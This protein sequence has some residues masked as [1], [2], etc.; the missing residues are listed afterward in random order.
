MKKE[1]SFQVRGLNLTIFLIQLDY[2][3]PPFFPS[4][5]WLPRTHE[6]GINS[7]PSF[8]TSNLSD[9]QF[10]CSSQ[11]H[12]DSKTLLKTACQKSVLD[13][14]GMPERCCVPQLKKACF[15]MLFRYLCAHL[16]KVIKEL[17]GF[18]IRTSLSKPNAPPLS[19]VPVPPQELAFINCS[20]FSKSYPSIYC[21]S[22]EETLMT[23]LLC[24]ISESVIFSRLSLF[25]RQRSCFSNFKSE[26]EIGILFTNH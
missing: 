5:L 21:R 11:T 4:P 3:S 1:K 25:E 2:G 18:K 16:G 17:T 22:L 7:R 15:I 19:Y 9:Q 6:L 12:S 26:S 10:R 14:M 23:F 13:Q 20:K 24:R 8:K